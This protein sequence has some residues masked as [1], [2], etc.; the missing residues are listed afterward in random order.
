MGVWLISVTATL[1]LLNTRVR[2]FQGEGGGGG[3]G[4]GG[5]DEDGEEKRDIVR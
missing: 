3:G 2:T 5:E 4:G 1:G